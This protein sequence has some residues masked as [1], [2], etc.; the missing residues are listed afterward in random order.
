[1]SLGIQILG[2]IPKYLKKNILSKTKDK[3][4]LYNEPSIFKYYIEIT[5]NSKTSYILS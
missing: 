1:M 5:P 3:K 2:V 4:L